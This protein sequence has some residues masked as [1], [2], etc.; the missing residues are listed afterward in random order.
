MSKGTLFPLSS[1][2]ACSLYII[3][4]QSNL[5]TFAVHKALAMRD[6]FCEFSLG[7]GQELRNLGLEQ[8]YQDHRSLPLG[9]GPPDYTDSSQ[10][11]FEQFMESMRPTLLVVMGMADEEMDHLIAEAR[12]E[13][14]QYKAFINIDFAYGRKPSIKDTNN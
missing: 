4:Q 13:S 6:V 1:V 7:M 3:I 14:D 12:K 9:W 8:T 10:L 5:S 11:N 2:V